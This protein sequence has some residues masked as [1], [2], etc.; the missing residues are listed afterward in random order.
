MMKKKMKKE[1]TDLG[2]TNVFYDDE[3]S[4]LGSVIS[5]MGVP[6][7]KNN[8]GLSDDAAPGD[9]GFAP[10]G[11]ISDNFTSYELSES[12]KAKK[13]TDSEEDNS[14]EESGDS[15]N[16]ES[17]VKDC[18]KDC[19]EKN[20]NASFKDCKNHLKKHKETSKYKLSLKDYLVCKKEMGKKKK[21]KK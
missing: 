17:M 5:Q 3:K 21:K 2:Y 12:K 6:G 10:T 14:D 11:R 4:W 7:V 20:P 19:F 9:I 16:V 13:E 18:L 15:G 8:S 1:S